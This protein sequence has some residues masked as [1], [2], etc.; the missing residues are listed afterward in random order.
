M[1][2]N[3]RRKQLW[4]YPHANP[5][6]TTILP[7]DFI[8]VGDFWY[9]AAMV[10]QGLGNEKRTMFWQSRDLY[11]WEKTEPYVSLEHR[12]DQVASSVTPATSC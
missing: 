5:D 12:D 11:D 8:R 1:I 6:Y 3:G 2:A 10:T 7:C 9:V 4:D